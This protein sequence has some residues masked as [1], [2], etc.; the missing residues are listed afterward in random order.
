MVTLRLD[1]AER[2]E[3]AEDTADGDVANGEAAGEVDDA[4]G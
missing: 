4:A 1:E 2:F 3:A